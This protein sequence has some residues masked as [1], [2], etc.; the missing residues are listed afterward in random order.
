MEDKITVNE[1]TG[2]I[3]LQAADIVS[4]SDT[5][6]TPKINYRSFDGHMKVLSANNPLLTEVEIWLLSN[7]Q[8]LNNS[9]YENLAENQF[10]F[11]DTPILVAYT[12]GGRHVGDG[13]NFRMV[14]GTDGVERPTFTDANSERIVGWIRSSSDIRIEMHGEEEWIVSK[15]NLWSWYAPELTEMLS[16]QGDDG[17]DVSI[18]TLVDDPEIV[19]GIEVYHKWTVLGT[20]ILGKGV[21]PAVTGAHIRTCSLDEAMQELKLRVA[22]YEEQESSKTKNTNERIVVKT[23]NRKQLKAIQERFPEHIVVNASDDGLNV[24]L[25]TKDGFPC[26]YAFGDANEKTIAPE[27]IEQISVNAVYQFASGREINVDLNSILDSLHAS[28]QDLNS[29]IAT[30]TAEKESLNQKVLDLNAELEK[31]QEAER[32]RRIQAVKAAANAALEKFN[33][34]QPDDEKVDDEMCKQVAAEADNGG[35]DGCCD[36]N[37]AWCG[38]ARAEEKVLAYCA[39]QVAKF[40]KVKAE[41]AEKEKA[42]AIR[43]QSAVFAWDKKADPAN[44]V[45]I[46]GLLARVNNK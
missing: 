45:G 41:K 38:E 13:H 29:Q 2:S 15:A 21:T 1:D 16:L 26:V 18:E 36:T 31:I 8:T 42:E 11:V 23:M 6:E 20:T 24:C 40:N 22:S 25:L 19:D 34:S 30:L 4:E 17:M 9:R 43:K 37:G 32:K 28:A 10:S 46:E 39:Q 7:K 44:L 3:T 12:Q 35:Y 27:R 5:P 14:R 33:A